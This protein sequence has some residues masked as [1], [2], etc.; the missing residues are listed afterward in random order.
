METQTTSPS[1][2]F[3]FSFPKSKFLF[4]FAGVVG[5]YSL[6]YLALLINV[7]CKTGAHIF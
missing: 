3:D 6:A 7:L 2:Q 5:L 1:S 4:L